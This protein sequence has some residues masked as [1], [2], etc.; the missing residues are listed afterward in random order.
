MGWFE[1]KFNVAFV[2]VGFLSL[3]MFKIMFV[4]IDW[5]W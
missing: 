2:A 4:V 5:L 1:M 3:F